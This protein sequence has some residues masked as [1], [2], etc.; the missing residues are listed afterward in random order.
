MKGLVDMTA[1]PVFGPCI[2]S[3]SFSTDH[4]T[5]QIRDLMDAL[6]SHKILDDTEAMRVLRLYREHE[7]E[8]CA[9]L[10][11]A[12]PSRMLSIAFANISSQGI[13]VSLGIYND[14]QKRHGKHILLRA[15]GSTHDLGDLPF[16]KSMT[17]NR[18]TFRTIRGA[19]RDANFHPEFLELDLN[20]QG[21][22]GGLKDSLE[23]LLLIHGQLQSY[24]DICIKEENIDI[25]IVSS[26]NRLKFKQRLV[27]DQ[28]VGIPEYNRFTLDS[29]GQ[30][31]RDAL[32]SAS[33]TQLRMESCSMGSSAFVAVLRA[34][35]GTLQVVELV[36]VAY[37]GDQCNLRNM[38][39][40]LHCLR[41]ELQLTTLILDDVRAMNKGYSG[42]SGVLL[43]K[44]RFW[45]G[46]Q[47]I[48]GGLDVL[49]GFDG[50]AWDDD[51]DDWFQNSIKSHEAEV[52]N[53]V[54]ESAI[55][56]VGYMALIAREAAGLKAHKVQYTEYKVSRAR[57]AHAMARVEAGQFDS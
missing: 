6:D 17:L 3:V 47:Q 25:R 13:R 39:P 33:F 52:R 48:C 36:D 34:L 24:F 28:I 54:D 44:G 20:G 56:H 37:W 9:F 12:G 42:D 23:K 2:K 49:A 18:A 40:V 57:A 46:Q 8:R 30:P 21:T 4:L 50:N 11:S 27:H 53:L 16:A 29:L 10:K 22:H 7:V 15:Y 26:R 5:N 32:T 31:V 41:H 1:H 14:T 51:L 38:A 55:D 35:A 45:H 19:C 43:A